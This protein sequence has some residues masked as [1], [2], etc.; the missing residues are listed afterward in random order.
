MPTD[1]QVQIER[2]RQRALEEIAKVRNKGRGCLTNQC[3]DSSPSNTQGAK[4]LFTWTVKCA[5]GQASRP[6]RSVSVQYRSTPPS[7]R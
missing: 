5:T 2:R 3:T 4:M 7:S 6:T 1:I